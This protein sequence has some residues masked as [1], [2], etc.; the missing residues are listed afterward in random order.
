MVQMALA[1]LAVAALLK[2]VLP[3]LVGIMG[4][5]IS[6]NIG[7]TIHIEET[8]NFGAGQL[9]VVRVR[10]RVLLLSVTQSGVQF[11]ADVTPQ[12][13]TSTVAPAFFE[14]M[15]R[16]ES[17]SEETLRQRAIVSPMN[18]EMSMTAATTL[19]EEAKQRMTSRTAGKSPEDIKIALDRLERLTS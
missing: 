13:S 5:K 1:L 15:D 12:S 6:T 18:D 2:W 17:E 16:A 14:M 7:G 4:K 10:D 8:A 19:I 11:L 3:K 9:N